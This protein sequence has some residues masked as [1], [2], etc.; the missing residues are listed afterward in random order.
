[1]EIAQLILTAAARAE[2]LGWRTITLKRLQR[3]ADGDETALPPDPAT[4]PRSAFG[5]SA[6]GADCYERERGRSQT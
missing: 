2:R 4:A 5:Q 6:Y 1:M 3:L